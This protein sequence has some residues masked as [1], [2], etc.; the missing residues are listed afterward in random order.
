MQ[1]AVI[2]FV[3]RSDLQLYASYQVHSHVYVDN[4]KPKTLVT[5]PPER[6]DETVDLPFPR[7]MQ[8]RRRKC[9]KTSLRVLLLDLPDGAVE[10]IASFLQPVAMAQMQSTCRHLRSLLSQ[11]RYSRLLASLH[12]RSSFDSSVLAKN[13][14]FRCCLQAVAHP[15][16]AILSFLDL[17][18][19][20]PCLWQERW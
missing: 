19:H 17:S 14:L 15:A 3:R 12:I 16:G 4:I 9:Q 18:R 5:S 13:N 6:S 1:L 20:I 11:D 10:S 8:T 2:V 7:I